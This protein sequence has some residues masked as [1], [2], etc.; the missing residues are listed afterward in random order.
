SEGDVPEPMVRLGPARTLALAEG[1]EAREIAMGYDLARR[2]DHEVRL[3]RE[4]IDARP[5]EARVR[6]RGAVLGAR[7]SRTEDRDE[8][9]GAGGEVTGE[10]HRAG[11]VREIGAHCRETIAQPAAPRRTV[12]DAT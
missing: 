12:T 4:Q 9:R 3:P 10:G 7:A 11:G 8:E 6:D 5:D 2:L 1:R